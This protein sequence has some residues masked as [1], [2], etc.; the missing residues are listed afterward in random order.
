MTRGCRARSVAAA[1]AVL[2]LAAAPTRAERIK[3]GEERAYSAES[4]HP[5]QPGEG[6]RPAVWTDTIVSPG[7]KFL[8]VHFVDM[9]LAAGDYV[10][11]SSPGGA[12]FWTYTGKGLHGTGEFWSFAVDGDTALVELHAGET[13]DYGYRI[14]RIGHG[15]ESFAALE[16]VCGTDGREDVACHPTINVDPVAR[17]L[18][19]SGGGMFV[20]TGWLV[21]G[22]NNSTLLTNNHCFSTQAEVNTLQAKFNF[23]KTT[24]GGGM[25]ANDEDFA[26]GTFLKT[27]PVNGGLDYTLCTLQGNPEATWGE[28]LATRKRVREGQLIYFPQHPG[29]QPKEI[30]FWED[31]AH[32]IR[33]KVDTVRATYG[34]S[35]PKSQTGYG[36]DSQGGSSGSPILDAGTLHAIAIHHFGGVSNNPCLNSGTSMNPICEDAGSLLNCV[37]N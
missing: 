6:H 3:V 37:T 29:G 36:C 34:G 35:A 19:Q 33:C 21:D 7:A 2:A 23:Q 22:A 17:L 9:K 1:T 25:N 31:S 11:V 27:H 13:P 10:S 14:D 26:G 5:Y 15:T 20:C 24:C 18:F 32:T 4:P 8:R 16:V 30:G 12:Q 28:Y